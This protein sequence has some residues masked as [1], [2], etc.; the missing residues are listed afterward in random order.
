MN[1]VSKYINRYKTQINN[2]GIYFL[3]ALI[4]MLL[5]LVTNPFI[6]KN[7]SPTDYAI[8]GYYTS[9]NSLFGPLVT[10][11]LLHYYTKRYFEL[12]EQKRLVLKSTLFKMLIFFSSIMFLVALFIVFIY[13]HFFNSDSEIPFFPFA[14]MSMIVLPLGGIYSLTLVE[15]RM[16]R[17]SRSFFKISAGRGVFGVLVACLFVVGFKWGAYGKLGSALITDLIFFLFVLI[18]N[19]ELWNI[20]FDWHIFKESL[21]FCWPLVL[22]SMLTFFSNGYDK[23]MLERGKDLV[24]LGIYSVGLS[25]ANYLQIFS[26]SINDTFQPDIFENVVKRNKKMVVRYIAIKIFIMSCIVGLFILFAPFLVKILTFG[27]YVDSTKYAIIIAISSITSML[28]YSVSQVTV[29]LGYS[30]ITLFNKIFGSVL[31]VLS[32]NFLIS[33][34]GAVGAAWGVVLSYLYFFAGNVAMVI[35]KYSKARKDENR[36][37]YLS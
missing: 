30:K 2:L 4:P 28:Y 12:D 5:S 34:Y 1:V 21:R 8:A 24:E 35:Y 31:S 37:P 10:F 27:R 15:L 13:T 6:A 14:I 11:Y 17:N 32:F 25:I 33:K 18:S 22:A 36:N 3:A 26:T 20:T 19:R 7:M 29:A 23:V 16:S 9:F